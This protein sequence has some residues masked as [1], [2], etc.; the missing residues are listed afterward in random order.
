MPIPDHVDSVN[1]DLE[2]DLT[3]LKIQCEAVLEK[4]RSIYGAED[5]RTIRAQELCN[6][7]QRL[8]WALSREG[9]IALPNVQN[10]RE[11]SPRQGVKKPLYRGRSQ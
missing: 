5:R 3:R 11:G 2:Q 7:L 6:D 10:T 4:V 9:P 1:I 8:H